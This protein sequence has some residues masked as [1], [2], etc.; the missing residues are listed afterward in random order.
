MHS[1]MRSLHFRGVDLHL[2][3]VEKVEVDL[4]RNVACPIAWAAKHA[5]DLRQLLQ[6]IYRIALIIELKNRIQKLFRAWLTIHR[7]CFVNCR[8]KNWRL[9]ACKID[10][11]FSRGTQI[12]QAIT[13]IRSESNTRSH[14]KFL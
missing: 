9:Y 6:K 8:R 14:F 3:G 7:C 2:A 1:R 10:N 13:K 12:G 4:A 11:C 5:L